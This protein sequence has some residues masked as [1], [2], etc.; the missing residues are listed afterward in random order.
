[1]LLWGLLTT[2]ALWR[3]A[4]AFNVLASP[5]RGPIGLAAGQGAIVVHWRQLDLF[6]GWAAL[7]V[8]FMAVGSGGMLRVRGLR[9]Q[10]MARLIGLLA[11]G[12]ILLALLNAAG[13]HFSGWGGGKALGVAADLTLALVGAIGVLRELHALAAE[14]PGGGVHLFA[15]WRLVTAQWILAWLA[16]TVF[17]RI[18]LRKDELLGSET[19]RQLLFA[20]PAFGVLPNVL[21]L[22]G[23]YLWNALRTPSPSQA[24]GSEPGAASE[25]RESGRG[26]AR[27]R[28][29]LVAMVAVNVGA[30][31]LV[32]RVPWP[33]LVGGILVIAGILLYMF[34]FP[35]GAWSRAKPW[36]LI[37]CGCSILAMVGVV[38]ER[39]LLLGSPAGMAFLSSAW[40]H[41]L[42]STVLFAGLQAL[43]AGGR[44][45][46]RGTR[47]LL[48]VATALL[49]TGVVLVSGLLLAT[50]FRQGEGQVPVLRLLFWAL[51]PQVV[52]LLALVPYG[53]KTAHSRNESR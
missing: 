35:R 1:V 10:R 42:V 15:L 8:W 44:E 30:A 29:W 50:S 38:A 12:G 36:F 11:A 34:G 13:D 33:G 40:R 2:L 18:T 22:A 9:E 48:I 53:L 4:L 20:L 24:I 51:L 32:L 52:G 25:G 16:A 46:V 21:M 31:L 23:I 39:V 49:V 45:G 41:L 26:R 47:R 7:L 17:L 43:G 5:N 37:A 6:V 27:T 19:A 14:M 3:L 28:A